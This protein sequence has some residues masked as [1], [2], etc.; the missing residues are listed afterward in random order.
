MITRRHAHGAASGGTTF[1]AA[2]VGPALQSRTAK[3]CFEPF[4]SA[5]A[6]DELADVRRETRSAVLRVARLGAKDR[7]HGHLRQLALVPEELVPDV[8]AEF[9][10]AEQM[11][12]RSAYDALAGSRSPRPFTSPHNAKVVSTGASGEDGGPSS[13]AMALSRDREVAPLTPADLVHFVEFFRRLD[14][15]KKEAP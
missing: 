6:I 8:H 1:Q 5:R 12:Q 3:L 11:V 14:A 13:D 2:H 4:T 9:E 15:W 10:L 7:H